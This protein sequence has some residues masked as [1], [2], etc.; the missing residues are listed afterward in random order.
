[1]TP[2]RVLQRPP[3]LR[4]A[5]LNFK[6]SDGGDAVL[7]LNVYYRSVFAAQAAASRPVW[8]N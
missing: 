5:E 7:L 8:G 2:E 6:W 1:M 3:W 4:K